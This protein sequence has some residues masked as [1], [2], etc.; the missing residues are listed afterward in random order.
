[1]DEGDDFSSWD[2]GGSDFTFDEGDDP[3]SNEGDFSGEGDAGTLPDESQF[4]PADESDAA[5]GDD[6]NNENP[7][8]RSGGASGGPSLNRQGQQ[9]PTPF[10]TQKPSAGTRP[11]LPRNNPYGNLSPNPRG[12]NPSLILLPVGDRQSQPRD[13]LAPI[14]RTSDRGVYDPSVYY[15]DNVY[16]VPG[17][18]NARTSGAVANTNAFAGMSTQ[19]MIIAGVVVLAAMILTRS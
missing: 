10:Q 5:S 19:T 18:P 8:A 13:G 14:Y 11:Q 9:K 17:R 16:G 15:P 4:E 1:M 3:W 12:T 7:S 2:D 6:S